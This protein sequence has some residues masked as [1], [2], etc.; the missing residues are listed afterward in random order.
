MKYHFIQ[1]E[2]TYTGAELSPHWIY[3]NFGILGD[4]VVAFIGPT[5]VTQN[6]MVDLEDVLNDD[7]IY[8]KRMLN[9]I[10]EIFALPLQQG[11]LLQRLFSGIIQD[12][13]NQALESANI[14]RRGDDLFYRETQKLSVSICTLSPTSILIHTGLNIDATGAP[15][16]ASGLS[17]E[18]GMSDA[19]VIEA[20]ATSCMRTFV[21]EWEDIKLSC[22]KVRAVI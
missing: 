4:S 18:L 13:L 20:F 21:E 19:K 14:K 22:C 12:K 8:S 2:I 15:V 6:D 7:F 9:F 16:E 11:V 5:K 1:E 10:I 3:R 17:S